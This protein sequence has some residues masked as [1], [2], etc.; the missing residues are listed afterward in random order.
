MSNEIGKKYDD[1]KPPV[2]RGMLHYF[3]R[4]IKEVAKCSLGGKLKYDVAYSDQN[5]S[6]VE[7]GEGRYI[8]A[9]GRHLLAMSTEGEF[10]LE[11]QRCVNLDIYHAAQ[12]AWNALAHLE[13]VLRR[14]G[15]L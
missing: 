4:A 7:D 14:K 8:D 9:C 1:G 2:V 3:P 13:L 12:V 10:D 11:M 5:W 15:A 6:R